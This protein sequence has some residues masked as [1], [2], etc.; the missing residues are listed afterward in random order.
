VINLPVVEGIA[1]RA[2]KFL[3]RLGV[4]GPFERM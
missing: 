2:A 4:R 1:Y 3:H